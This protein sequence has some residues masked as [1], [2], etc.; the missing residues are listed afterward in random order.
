MRIQLREKAGRLRTAILAGVAVTVAFAAVAGPAA[1]TG[2]REWRAACTRDA[3]IHCTL[4]ALAGDR[5]GVRDCMMRKLSR[6]SK[7]CR[8]VIDAAPDDA[9]QKLSARGP[10]GIGP[11][12]QAGNQASR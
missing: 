3:I 1:E 6:L 4:P 10:T 8:V 11:L 2:E 7:K 9:G 12:G 5:L